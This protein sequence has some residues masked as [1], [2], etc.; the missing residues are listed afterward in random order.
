MRSSANI[1][2]FRLSKG[3]YKSFK[4]AFKTHALREQEI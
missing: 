4:S 1:M 3:D 2:G